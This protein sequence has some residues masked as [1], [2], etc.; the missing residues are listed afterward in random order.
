MSAIMIMLGPDSYERFTA[1]LIEAMACVSD[2]TP[3]I[4]IVSG[5]PANPAEPTKITDFEESMTL[6]LHSYENDLIQCLEYQK[7][8]I[9]SIFGIPD[10]ILFGHRPVK[11]PPAPPR[12]KHFKPSKGRS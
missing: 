12:R 5:T 7:D 10:R 8:I 1:D 9:S 6:E 4:L 11:L 3:T 2:S